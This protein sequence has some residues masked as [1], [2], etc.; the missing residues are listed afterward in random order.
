MTTSQDEPGSLSRAQNGDILAYMLRVG[1][2]PT[3]ETPLGTH[4]ARSRRLL[5]A[6]ISPSSA[7]SA[8]APGGQ[9]GS[10]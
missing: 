2:F 7:W 8:A 6:R 10:A 4:P 3:G 5:S 1:G 9:D